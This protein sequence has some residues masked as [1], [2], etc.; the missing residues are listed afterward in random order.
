MLA[1]DQALSLKLI[2]FG[3]ATIVV[4]G[5]ECA[6]QAGSPGYYAPEILNNQPYGPPVDMWSLGVTAYILYVFIISI[7]TE[8]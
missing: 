5:I 3:L 7:S 2:D 8:N 6:E 4:E 1:D